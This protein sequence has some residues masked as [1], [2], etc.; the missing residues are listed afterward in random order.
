M[1][2][3]TSSGRASAD[4]LRAAR[5]LI[6]TPDRWTKEWYARDAKGEWADL[7]KAT[8]F[9]AVGA[10]AKASGVDDPTGFEDEDISHFLA[11]AVGCDYIVA[12]N[13]R[14][15]RTHPEVLAAFDRAIALAEQAQS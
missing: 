12:W 14:A 13:D 10:L 2:A 9:C 6:A 15:E 5:E 7:S 11:V 1:I 4:I 3:P 8:C